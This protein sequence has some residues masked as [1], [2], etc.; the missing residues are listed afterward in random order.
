MCSDHQKET[1]MSNLLSIRPHTLSP[2]IEPFR[3]MRDFLRWDPYRDTQGE[4]E[5]GAYFLPSFDVKE[6]AEAY[7]FTADMPGI[8]DQDLDIDLTGNR[9]T[10]KGRREAQPRI[11]GETLHMVERAIGTFTR[12]FTLPEAVDPGEVKADLKQGV[13]TL[14]IPKRPETRPQ[15]IHINS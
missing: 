12:S 13:L 11:E 1:T 5:P 2:V 15:K 6:T 8:R 3:L 14:T 7:V 10:V 9:L 4:L